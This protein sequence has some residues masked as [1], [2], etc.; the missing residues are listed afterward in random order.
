MVD[1]A[2]AER[3]GTGQGEVS[4]AVSVTGA[5][6]GHV[7]VACSS[8]ASRHAAAALLG[9]ELADVSGDDIAD[10]LGELAN[11]IGGNVKSLLPEPSALSLPHVVIA[12]NDS[13]SRWPS[14]TE[15]C[16]LAAIW[17]DEPFLV[18]V[19]ESNNREGAT[20]A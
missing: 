2:P 15:L 14:V 19:L 6:R 3:L 8:A 13:S 17:Q 7:V 5:W 11:V 16:R 4:A 20:A 1:Y 10:A 12:Q 9:V 18:S